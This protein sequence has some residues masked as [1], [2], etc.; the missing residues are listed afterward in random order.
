M[1]RED[2]CEKR[3]AETQR[4]LVNIKREHER[5]RTGGG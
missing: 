4:R 1:A 2:V 5:E 3:D